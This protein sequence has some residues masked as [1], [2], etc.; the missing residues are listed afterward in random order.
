MEMG[1]EDLEADIDRL[2]R[3]IK[4]EL[5]TLTQAD[6]TGLRDSID[7]LGA[8]AKR[9]AAVPELLAALQ[10]VIRVAIAKA[11]GG[12]TVATKDITDRQVCE[13]VR[14]WK[15]TNVFADELLATR[16]GQPL[17]VATSALERAERRGLIDYGVSLRTAWLTDA[18]TRYT[19]VDWRPLRRPETQRPAPT[20]RWTQRWPA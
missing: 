9:G 8:M 4:D 13:A 7:L 18:G 17:K 11:A 2:V 14:D 20:I 16:T 15:H 3:D 12:L 10:G 1:M 6:T 19:A 5:S